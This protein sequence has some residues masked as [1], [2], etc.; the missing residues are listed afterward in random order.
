[1]RT[2]SP[3]RSRIKRPAIR[4]HDE[5]MLGVRTDPECN[6]HRIM[7]P[8]R[9]MFEALTVTPGSLPIGAFPLL[10][11]IFP[12]GSSDSEKAACLLRLFKMALQPEDDV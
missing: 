1:V 3:R 5:Q 8:I 10:E 7:I 11:G 9:P 12:P 4:R 2:V 6:L